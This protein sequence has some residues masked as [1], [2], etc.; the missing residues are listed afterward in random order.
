M[1]KRRFYDL[2]EEPNVSL[3]K[4]TRSLGEVGKASYDSFEFNSKDFIA[5]MPSEI[6]HIILS[7]VHTIDLKSLTQTSKVVYYLCSD[8][9]FNR[10]SLSVYHPLSMTSDQAKVY[11]AVVRGESLFCSGTAGT[12]KSFIIDAISDYCENTEEDMCFLK[13]A[14]TGIAAFNI[15]GATL[16]SLFPVTFGLRCVD[17]I[18]AFDVWLATNRSI[19]TTQYYSDCKILAIEEVGMVS[20]VDLSRLD[21]HLRRAQNPSLPFGGVQIVAFGDFLQLPPIQQERGTRQIN[22][23]FNCPIWAVV[24]PNCSYR[25]TQVIRQRNR[26]DVDFLSCVRTGVIPISSQGFINEM[27]SQQSFPSA[28]FIFPRRNQV[29]EFTEKKLDALMGTRFEYHADDVR[30]DPSSQPPDILPQNLVVKA[31][32]RVMLKINYKT[33]K[34]LVNGAL[35]TIVRFE[36]ADEILEQMM[37]NQTRLQHEFSSDKGIVC[38]KIGEC[39]GNTT[40]YPIVQFDHLADLYAIGYYKTCSYARVTVRSSLMCG[41]IVLASRTQLPIDLAFAFTVHKIQGTTL[42]AANI[43]VN[44]SFAPGLDFTAL[45]RVRSLE[46]VSLRNFSAVNIRVNHTAVKFEKKTKWK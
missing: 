8:E 3:S 45:S 12:G 40:M 35:G 26:R 10:R 4:Q 44:G 27:L 42:D 36:E 22:C 13:G 16:A 39:K 32:A 30:M 9:L 34:G 37:L 23:A 31:G 41:N 24:F 21:V 5:S 28:P 43:D 14:P 17:D 15:K 1:S 7:T 19:Q 33:Q 18:A 46:N 29:E 25:L 2:E 6:I 38:E 20:G 11:K